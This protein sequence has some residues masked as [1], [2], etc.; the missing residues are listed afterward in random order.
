MQQR[1]AAE[2]LSAASESLNVDEFYA[3]YNRDLELDSLLEDFKFRFQIRHV[4][5]LTAGL[6]VVLSLWKIANFAGLLLLTFVGLGG[7]HFY[8]AFRERKR[9]AEVE[10]RRDRL[11]EIM[12]ARN[13]GGA[14]DDDGFEAAA[15]EI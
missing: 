6:A 10:A 8:L 13:A 12:R 4:M 7:A 14:A 5:L 3:D 15:S 9:Q 2:R 11:L 1:H